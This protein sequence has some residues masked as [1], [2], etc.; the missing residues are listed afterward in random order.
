MS[1][2]PRKSSKWLS[3]CHWNFWSNQNNYFLNWMVDIY[4]QL[5]LNRNVLLPLPPFSS[6]FFVT[7]LKGLWNGLES[8]V[9]RFECARSN[10]N[11]TSW[12]WQKPLNKHLKLLT[13]M[14]KI[15]ESVL[16]R[17]DEGSWELTKALNK[18]VKLLN[19]TLLNLMRAL[20]SRWKC[21]RVGGQTR[22][23]VWALWIN[24]NWY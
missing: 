7:L 11:K 18:R 8:R 19:V 9:T 14:F 21:I 23:R 10:E 16:D 17:F 13:C 12:S 3:S 1:S 15:Y 4:V 6:T 24:L 2:S 20:E 22:M 5:L